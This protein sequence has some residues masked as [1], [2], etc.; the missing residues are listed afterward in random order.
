MIAARTLG[1]KLEEVL[2]VP[3]DTS[4]VPD[5]GPTVASRTAMVVGH[6][7]EKACL[8]LAARLA[9]WKRGG[10]AGGAADSDAATVTAP[11]GAASTD[12]A[13]PG[14]PP[15]AALSGDDFRRA[16]AAVLQSGTRLTG[17]SRYEKPSYVEWDEKN[18]RGDAYATYGWAAYACEVEVDVRSCEAR[19]VAFVAH[20]DVGKV[21]HPVLA[22][23]QVQGGV[24]QAIGWSLYE[25][26]VYDKGR[27][28]NAALSTYVIPTFADVPPITVMFAETPYPYGPLGAKGI[29]ELPMDGPAPAIANA[30]SRALDVE[31]ARIPCLPEYLMSLIEESASH[32]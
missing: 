2:V 20:Q 4:R 24:V 9:Q 18:Y 10:E 13:T 26:V 11:T 32:V 31:V 5:S 8:D 23:G 29:G 27:V 1:L 30:L 6:L 25:N 7:V 21:L 16:A 19:V 15:T 17:R 28:M 22:T 12:P 14:T 3:P